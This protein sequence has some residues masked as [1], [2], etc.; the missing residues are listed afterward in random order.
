ME[1][2]GCSYSHKGYVVSGTSLVEG[3]PDIGLEH[4]SRIAKARQAVTAKVCWSKGHSRLTPQ[5]GDLHVDG[6]S[7]DE[8]FNGDQHSNMDLR[9]ISEA[10]MQS[11]KAPRLFCTLPPEAPDLIAE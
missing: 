4:F 10:K 1:E 11:D 8:L 2:P 3:T 6:V 9:H 5:P 7:F